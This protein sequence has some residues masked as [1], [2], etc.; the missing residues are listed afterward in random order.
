MGPVGSGK[1]VACCMK[2]LKKA[3]EQAPGPDGVRRTRWVIV[4]NSYPELKSTTIATWTEWFP[5]ELFG[6][7]KYDAPISHTLQL[8]PD[9]EM[10]VWFLAMDMP[11]DA[12]K[13]LSLEVTGV[14]LNE[15]RE[16]PKAILD[17]A[18]A[19]VGRYPGP[20]AGGCSWRGVMMDTNPPDDDHWWYELAEEIQ[21]EN[22]EFFRQP[23]GLDPDA[24]N[25]D[26]LVQTP[27]T[28][29]LPVGHPERRAKGREYY[30]HLIPGK[31]P[32]W[33]K[34]YVEG[35]YGS[36]SDGRPIY[37][38]F[39]D[40][41]HVSPVPLQPYRGLPLLLGWDFGLTPACAIGQLSARGQL[42]VLHEFTS[43]NSGIK[44]FANNEVKPFLAMNYPDSKILSFIDPAGAPRAQTDERTCRDILKEAG[45][46]PTL[47]P[48]NS[49]TARREA[50]AGFLSRL[51]D[52]QPG[53]L[54]D[55]RCKVLRKGMNGDY[56]FRRVQ[57]AGE[58]RYHDQ[59]E[60]NAVSHVCEALQYL[61]LHVDG[62]RSS[63]KKKQ[64]PPPQ[65]THVAVTSA[66]Y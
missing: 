24:E 48:T 64:K 22:M 23:S 31:S 20:M 51:I 65:R 10:T 66:G 17:A 38:E 46:H 21:P 42:R 61:A 1:S 55:P 30:T 34:V 63:A 27:Y 44:Q 25:L 9:C 50:V 19:R 62:A 49:F 53:F 13:L 32:N 58:E 7:V 4:R 59:P 12:K 41:I 37:P 36:V 14:W 52:G 29:K 15:A 18:T 3:F 16:L 5:P 26:Y 56:R 39:S 45:L 40:T 2:I 28:L 47:A 11:D 33:V 57:V 60:K 43:T 8:A 54:L 6:K 35:Q